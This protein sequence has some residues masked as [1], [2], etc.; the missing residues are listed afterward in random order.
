MPLWARSS[1]AFATMIA[2][3]SLPMSC[4]SMSA[5]AMC[6]IFHWVQLAGAGRKS[7]IHPA[8]QMPWRVLLS[9]VDRTTS[10]QSMAWMELLESTVTCAPTSLKGRALGIR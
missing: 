6:E 5:M 7:S 3:S 8:Q 9:S 1:I 10:M 2:S 4:R